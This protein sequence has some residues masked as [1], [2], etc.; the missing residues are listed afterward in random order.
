MSEA[1]AVLQAVLFGFPVG[2]QVGLRVKAGQIECFGGE[3]ALGHAPNWN[4]VK[5]K[6]LV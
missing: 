4:S 2:K 5:I 3:F 1:V 6:H